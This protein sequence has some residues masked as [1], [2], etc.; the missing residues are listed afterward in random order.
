MDRDVNFATAAASAEEIYASASQGD[1]N[2]AQ[3]RALLFLRHV[4]NAF[5]SFDPQWGTP[6]PQSL[7]IVLKKA[8]LLEDLEDDDA[9]ED[10]VAR[11]LKHAEDSLKRLLQRQRTGIVRNRVIMPVH[12]A[13][14]FDGA[15]VAWLSRKPG[16]NIREKLSG[17]PYLL[18]VKRRM[19]NNSAENRLLKAFSI[20]LQELLS[21]RLECF[22][23]DEDADQMLGRLSLWLRS[24]E[25]QEIDRWAHLP[26]NNTLLQNRAYRTVWDSWSW[27]QSLESDIQRDRE[28]LRCDWL[29]LLYWV[30]ASRLDLSEAIRIPEQPCFFEPAGFPIRPELGILSGLLDPKGVRSSASRNPAFGEKTDFRLELVEKRL[31]IELQIRGSATKIKCSPA[32]EGMAKID[33]TISGSGKKPLTVAL[34]LAGAEEIC[35][36]VLNRHS[37][38]EPKG[39]PITPA[40]EGASVAEHAVIDV[41]SLYPRAATTHGGSSTLPFRLLMQYWEADKDVPEP[42]DLGKSDAVALRPEAPCVSILDL[43]SSKAS[44]REDL[45][46]RAAISFGAKLKAAQDASKATYLYPDGVNEFL[47]E[48]I[49]KS[50]NFHFER[51]A[52]LPRSIGAAF[53]WQASK[54][55]ANTG[56]KPGDCLAVLDYAEDH[57]TITPL[58]ACKVPE[59]VT[60]VLGSK[61]PVCWERHPSIALEGDEAFS[62]NTKAINILKDQKCPF[63]DEIVRLTGHQ[64]L[65]D[66]GDKLSW[67]DDRDRWFTPTSVGGSS[68]IS[69]KASKELAARLSEAREQVGARGR[70]LV[71]Q[72]PDLKRGADIMKSVSATRMRQRSP[73]R[74]SFQPDPCKGGLHLEELQGRVPRDPLW[75]DHLPDLSMRVLGDGRYTLFHLVKNKKVAPIIGEPTPIEI[76]ETF[77]LPKGSPFYSFPLVQ[78]EHGREIHY[79]AELRSPHFPLSEDLKVKLQMTYTYGSDDPYS[80]TF[81]ASQ[82]DAGKVGFKFLKVKWERE[83]AQKQRDG[84]EVESPQFPPRLEWKDFR[85][86]PSLKGGT[87]DLIDWIQRTL[88]RRINLFCLRFPTLT[89]WN[90]G[91]NLEEANAPKAFRKVVQ[92]AVADLSELLEEVEDRFLHD[93]LDDLRFEAFFFLSCLHQDAPEVVFRML[94]QVIGSRNLRD[95]HTY[96]RN[97]AYS[98]GCAKEPV[99][100][101]LWEEVIGIVTS[102]NNSQRASTCL[103]IMGIAGWR[104]RDL[105]RL[106]TGKQ[107][108]EVSDK[109]RKALRREMGQLVK[110]NPKTNRKHVSPFIIWKLELLLGLLRTRDSEDEKITGLLVPGSEICRDFARIV[111]EFTDEITDFHFESRIQLE[112]NK[113]DD[114]HKTPDLLYA[115]RLYLTGDTG[116]GSIRIS[117]IHES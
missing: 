40:A 91:H 86:H 65:L 56:V 2:S 48:R 38:G 32:K 81:I 39:T 78:G 67:V 93:E 7:S 99:Q 5:A 92:S 73:E 61:A 85:K 114:F 98:I 12:A 17:T 20:R 46:G 41:G 74:I 33:V 84:M 1:E 26:P 8:S 6:S 29:N 47:L 108:K 113:P 76:K 30:I 4:F 90:N 104:C 16:R 23:G 107:V 117:G 42:V 27:L 69:K 95:L 79:V 25:A 80:L 45:L 101:Y 83:D 87:S 70:I 13:R 50:M 62:P 64:G 111:E 31:E 58:V 57:V 43:L 18:A 52:P 89:V 94:E 51:A 66:D 77:V 115:L 68:G 36:I 11:I 24:E 14:E 53:S 22:S 112:L 72:L 34:D 110:R 28:R 102:D 97:L 116:A 49:R 9:P 96:G 88:D 21:A 44:T 10:R 109:L 59:R 82:E 75:K 3:A 37:I 105:I 55:F 106:L 19:S 103:Q 63:P 35:E 71:L 54:N 15:S 60:K 100:S